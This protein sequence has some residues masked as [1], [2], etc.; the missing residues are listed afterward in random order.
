MHDELPTQTLYRSTATEWSK[1]KKARTVGGSSK[2]AGNYSQDNEANA[3]EIAGV[4]TIPQL[5]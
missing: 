5:D 2:A 4:L 1:S 3:D